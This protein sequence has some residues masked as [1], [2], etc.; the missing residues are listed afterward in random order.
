MTGVVLGGFMLADAVKRGQDYEIVLDS[1]NLVMMVGELVS[2]VLAM[3]G[4]SWAGPLGCVFAA[5][6]FVVM[7]IQFLWGLISP[8]KGPVEEYV[9]RVLV[10]ANLADAA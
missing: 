5:A 1:L 8:P 7:I 10:P 2:W 9:D 4:F 3:F 6:G